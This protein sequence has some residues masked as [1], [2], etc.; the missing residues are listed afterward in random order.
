MTVATA[1]RV[2]VVDDEPEIR[3]VLKM[4]LAA[5]GYAVDTA[6]GGQEGLERVR[7]G[8]PDVVVLDL[9]MPDLAGVDVIRAVRAWSAVPI[10]VLS[11]RTEEQEKVR[12]LNLGAD[13][14][15]TKPFGMD[16]LVARIRVAMRHAGSTD[17]MDP[18]FRTG[19]LCLDFER[20]RVTVRDEPV[21]LSP[22]EYAI[23]KALA[24]H[25]GKILT[26]RALL[27]AGWG[28]DYGTETNYLHVYIRRLRHKIEADP[29]NP[30]YLV[31]EPGAGYRLNLE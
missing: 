31:T 17:P 18:V 22:T 29:A 20:R 9:M 28:P 19:E 2:L 7:R 16:E 4:G 30:R 5:K 3:R 23:L 27:Q 15:L 11:V 26:Q 8:L 6:A 1:A 24:Q 10:I 25:G 21:A 13:D 12:A 14:Y